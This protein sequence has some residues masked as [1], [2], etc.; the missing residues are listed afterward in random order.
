MESM[1]K[2]CVARLSWKVQADCTDMC[3]TVLR[4]KYSINEEDDDL[5]AKPYDSALWKS[6]INVMLVI[7]DYSF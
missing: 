3:L 6:I 7:D 2:A 1:N 5:I 4:G